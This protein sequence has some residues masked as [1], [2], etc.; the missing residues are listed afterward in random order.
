M[1]RVHEAFQIRYCLLCDNGWNAS[2]RSPVVSDEFCKPPANR[3]RAVWCPDNGS[4]SQ[5]MSS[6]AV[7]FVLKDLNCGT[8][9]IRAGHFPH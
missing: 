7:A 6:S 3:K 1:A 4:V 8:A 9:V 2:S 5:E